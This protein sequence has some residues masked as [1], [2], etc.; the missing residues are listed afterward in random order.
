M[1]YEKC[2][3]SLDSWNTWPE[4][5]RAALVIQAAKNAAYHASSYGVPAEAQALTGAVYIGIVER[6]A[7][8]A[9]AAANAKQAAAG[10]PALT[11]AQVAARAAHAVIEADRRSYHRQYSVSLEEPQRIDA[12]TDTEADALLSLEVRSFAA[13]RDAVDQTI[14]QLLAQEQTEREI[15]HQVSLSHVAVHK[16]IVRMRQALRQRIA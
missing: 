7:P 8:D 11:F 13:G 6:L 3:A 16:R 1:E 2:T 10:K 12:G 4:S 5:D 14:L 9:L 15:A